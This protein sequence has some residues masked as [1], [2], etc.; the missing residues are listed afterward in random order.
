MHWPKGVA[1]AAAHAAVLT[2]LWLW[3][4]RPVPGPA[5][6]DVSGTVAFVGALGVV[7]VLWGFL[8]GVLPR[9]TDVA[10]TYARVLGTWFGTTVLTA[11][12]VPVLSPVT[13]GGFLRLPAPDEVALALTVGVFVLFVPAAL[14]AAAGVFCRVVV[15]RAGRRRGWRSPPGPSGSGGRTR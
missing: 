2:G 11:L 4:A 9:R 12:L 6:D 15:R 7:V 1:T 13:E 8:D 5:S 3:L 10:V 14:A